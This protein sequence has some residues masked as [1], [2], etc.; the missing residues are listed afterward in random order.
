[1]PPSCIRHKSIDLPNV[2]KYVMGT[3]LI[4]VTHVHDAAVKKRSISGILTRVD[5]GRESRMVPADMVN[6]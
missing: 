6:R 5:W 2:E 1:M 3:V 4:P